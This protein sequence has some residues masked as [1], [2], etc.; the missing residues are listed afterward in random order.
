[1]AL[2]S[3]NFLLF[4]LGVLILYYIVPKRFQWVLLLIASYAFYII[5]GVEQVFF[6]IGTT[7]VTYGSG[8]WM[9][10]Q[11]NRYR[12]ELEAN[13]G[14]EKEQ[15]QSIKKKMTAK[16]HRIQALTV[17]IDLLVLALVKYSSFVIENINSV[18]KKV[19]GTGEIPLLNILVPLGISFYTFMAIGYVID[20]G[21]GKYEAEKNVG[22]LALFLSFFPSIVQGPISRF[23]EIG[24]RLVAEHK[25]QYENI[26]YGAQ[27]IM[28]GFFK[29]L[30]IAD[31]LAP[32]ISGIFS[33]D[34][35]KKF[36]GTAL[37][38]GMVGYALQIYCDFSGGIDITRGAAR[39]LGIELPLNFE[40]PYFAK[41][42][43]EYWRRWHMTLGAWMKEY[44]FYAIM[45][46]KPISKL[47]KK[48]KNKYGQKA[49]KYIPSIITSF[50]VFLLMGIW[51]GSNWRYVA[52]GLYNAVLISG[53]VALEGVFKK[54][55]ELAHI[56]TQS[57]PWKFFMMIRTFLLLSIAKLLVI[58]P[59]LG[60]A[61]NSLKKM[62]TSFKLTFYEEYVKQ[63]IDLGYKNYI[64]LGVALL[65][66]L[67]ISIIQEN[68]VHI[69]EGIAKRNIVL[70]WTLYF[71]ML[72]I[73]L[74]FGVYGPE[75][76]SAS[77]IYQAY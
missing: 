66:V 3:F 13:P 45:L 36:S 32:L 18:I 27:L 46:S 15:K 72:I 76:D 60:M 23:E 17:A 63:G 29:K 24:S 14:M 54:M 52:Y 56:N 49:S 4:F 70:R 11:R 73:I 69:R 26:T 48:V 16:I 21:R 61:F 37:F 19:G 35:N 42:V 5:G 22:K 67:V 75:Y 68:G 65:I 77:F 40:R 28:W 50:I 43:A 57:K 20:I 51:H 38:V 71:L 31:R 30:V 53:S 7:L 44:V 25:L 47:S 2:T 34:L 58:S 64:V 74:V 1:M 41:T 12:A 6:L 62:F 33:L 9:Q 55:A 10:R 39:M 59:S 8:L